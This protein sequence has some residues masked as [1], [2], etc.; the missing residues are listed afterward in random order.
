VPRDFDR[1]LDGSQRWTWARQ[2][3]KQRHP[4]KAASG[5]NVTTFREL[6]LSAP[7]LDLA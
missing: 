7:N 5:K 3:T 1:S 4:I 2:I 6:L